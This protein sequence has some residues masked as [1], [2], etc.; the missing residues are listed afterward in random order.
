MGILNDIVVVK[1]SGQ[2]VSFNGSKIAIA[3]KHAFDDVSSDYDYKSVNKVYEKTLKYIIDNYKSRKTINVED[4]QDIIEGILKNSNYHNEYKAFKKYRNSRAES[5]RAFSLKQQHK[6]VKV[7]EKIG[8]LNVDSGKPFENL[9]LFG[10]TISR[11]YVKSYVMD[12]KYVRLHE[13]GRIYIHNMPYFDFGYINSTH[14]IIDDAIYNDC[15]LQELS[16]VKSEVNDEIAIDDLDLAF[17]GFALLKYKLIF[18]DIVSRYLKIVGIYSFINVRKLYEIINK[19][20]SICYDLN[21]FSMFL[22]NEQIK[23]IFEVAHNDTLS[24]LRDYLYKKFEKL[25]VNL[26]HNIARNKLYSVSVSKHNSFIKDI[27]VEVFSKLDYLDNVVLVYKIA[28]NYDIETI[29]KLLN[30]NLRLNFDNCDY[31]GNGLKI[32][33]AHGR[34]NIAYTS[35]NLARLGIK[36]RSLSTEFYNELDE[37]IDLSR[38]EL[39]FVFESIGDKLKDNYQVLFNGNILDDEKLESGQRIRK[40][41][42][43]GTLNVNLVGLKECGLIIDEAS[44]QRIVIKLIKYINSKFKKIAFDTKLNFTVSAIDDASNKE[45]IALDKTI[46]GL[47]NNVT[48]K[49]KYENISSLNFKNINDDIGYISEYQRLLTGG[50][51]VTFRILKN[52]TIKDLRKIMDIFIKYHVSYVKL[53]CGV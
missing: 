14:L 9:D 34:S 40:V 24:S 29:Y 26:N 36:Y 13:E 50:N 1:R 35:I 48:K 16:L 19:L 2:R 52:L 53:G 15:L 6:F 46:Y 12:S 44:Y 45:L 41:I 39:L 25:F 10:E 47:I 21:V 33:D 27:I 20:D 4:I 7:I 32:D 51:M 22:Q 11:E 31:F 18:K 43:N 30:K 23:N 38:N 5:R 28:D 42:K 8:M 37:L 17:S 49:D 3:I